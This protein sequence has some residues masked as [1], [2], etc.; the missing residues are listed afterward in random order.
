[1]NKFFNIKVDAKSALPIYEQVKRSIKLAIFSGRLEDG[2]QVRSIRE[3]SLKL[4]INPNTI[5]KVYSQLEAEGFLISRP[6]AGYF[7]K[8]DRKK[9]QREKH[10]LFEEL[11]TEYVAKMLELGYS[12][13]ELIHE[14]R[15]YGRNSSFEKNLKEFESAGY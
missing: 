4:R 14:I 15:K 6:G 1:M 11:T 5:I 3:L 13:D 2:D 9:M 12:M 7:V 8:L 10:G